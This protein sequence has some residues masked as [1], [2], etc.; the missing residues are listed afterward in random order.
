MSL[1]KLRGGKMRFVGTHVKREN[2]D[3]N[4]E[5]GSYRKHRSD[6]ASTFN[7]SGSCRIERS[8][9]NRGVDFGVL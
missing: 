3:S 8:M 5:S 4:I 9:F 6:P 1:K 7:V 2:G